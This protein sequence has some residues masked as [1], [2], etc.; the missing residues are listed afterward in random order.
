MKFNDAYRTFFE[1]RRNI[2]PKCLLP[3]LFTQNMHMEFQCF[4]FLFKTEIE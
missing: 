3:Q 4:Y 2:L 1:K